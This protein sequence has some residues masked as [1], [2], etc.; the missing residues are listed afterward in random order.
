MEVL[1]KAAAVAVVGAVLGLV[2]KKNTPEISLLLSMAI[3]CAVLALGAELL[4][5]VLDFVTSLTEVTNISSAS[6]SAVLKAVGI[7]IV[8]R[9]AVDICKDSGQTSAASSVELAGTVTA[10]FVAMPLMETV[11]EMIRSLL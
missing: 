3:S 4:K 8:T 2:L 5:D 10:L 11:L 9:I 1:L 6:I 7:G